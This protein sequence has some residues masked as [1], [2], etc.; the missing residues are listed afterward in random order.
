[1]RIFI[2]LDDHNAVNRGD[3]RMQDHKKIRPRI[4]SRSSRK[5]S[6]GMNIW[7]WFAAAVFWTAVW[8]ASYM[9]IH[10]DLLLASPLQVLGSLAILGRQPG[11]WFSVLYSILRIESGYFLGVLAGTLLAVLTVR[12]VWVYRFLYPVISAIRSTPVASFI[13]LALVWMSSGRVVIFI[14]F[15]MVMPVIWA[16]VAEGIRKIDPLLHEMAFV[17]R[18]TRS[19]TLRFIDIPSV[20][21]F[22]VAAATTGLGLAWK[23]GIAAEVLS[24][25]RNSLGGL[26][27]EAK[28]YL[29]TPDLLA[30]TAVIILLSL[31]LEK[32]LVSV[33]ALAGKYFHSHGRSEVT[34][35]IAV[36][37]KVPE[38]GKKE[39]GTV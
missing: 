18:L 31:L 39:G 24:T 21:P 4:Y 20:S 6:T 36:R 30:H 32:L 5:T 16:N 34:A 3:I 17:F 35:N 8:Q 7:Y 37:E 26:L 12:F 1:M 9:V 13:I 23:A 28:I 38:A 22:F 14:V 15:L 29:E 25:P 19:Q 27:Y 2:G 33:L 11:F 10:N